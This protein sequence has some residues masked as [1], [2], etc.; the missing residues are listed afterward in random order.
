MLFVARWLPGGVTALPARF[1]RQLSLSALALLSLSTLAWVIAG[2]T[3]LDPS[4]TA[5]A[6]LF[7]TYPTWRLSLLGSIA[8]ALVLFILLK[9]PAHYLCTPFHSLLCAI[10]MMASAWI[11]RW[12]ILMSVQEV[13]KYGAGLYL[14]S[15]PLGSNGLL[16][17]LGIF[18]LCTALLAMLT[19]F[20]GRYPSFAAL[21]PQNT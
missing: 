20:I 19:W 9:V 13:P 21:R 4:F 17:I 5:A 12:I 18:G 6:E 1:V 2:L 11:F 7:S 14:H 15:M 3:G 16:G 8:L 10:F